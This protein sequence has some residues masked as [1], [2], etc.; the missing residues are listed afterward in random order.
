MVANMPIDE[1]GHQATQGAARRSRLLQHGVAVIPFF[2]G[3]FDSFDLA[4]DSPHP[5]QEFLVVCDMG[6]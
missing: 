1:F 5:R 6:H 2:Y 3:A 4:P